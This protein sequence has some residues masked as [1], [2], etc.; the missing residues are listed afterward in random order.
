MK[1]QVW[2]C[3]VGGGVRFD[4]DQVRLPGDREVVDT[5]AQRGVA[6]DGPVEVQVIGAVE[7]LVV[8]V[9]PQ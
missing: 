6:S 1:W 9:D 5:T 8:A 2:P 4:D 7:P 3:T